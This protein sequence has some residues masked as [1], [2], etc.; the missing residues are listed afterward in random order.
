MTLIKLKVAEKLA[1][2]ARKPDH[3]P[4]AMLILTQRMVRISL[5]RLSEI[6]AERRVFRREAAKLQGYPY[7]QLQMDKLLEKSRSHR[8]DDI[9]DIKQGL[10]GMG[11]HLIKDTDNSYDA[12]GFDSLCDL[13]SINPIHRPAIPNDERGLAGLIYVARLENSAS[14]QSDGWGE[15]GPLFEACFM[16]MMHWIKT[17]PECDLPDLF[18]PNSPFA[19]AEIVPVKTGVTLQ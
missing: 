12:I 3:S 19:G 13:L 18:G 17:A 16:A 1:K 15:G 4:R 11:Y 6:R 14:P 8:D 2:I 5:A 9:R 10:I 7:V